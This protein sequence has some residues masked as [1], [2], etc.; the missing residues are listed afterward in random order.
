MLDTLNMP[1]RFNLC[2]D[3]VG[4]ADHGRRSEAIARLRSVIEQERQIPHSAEDQGY[5]R[6]AEMVLD[7]LEE[8]LP[9]HYAASSA[10]RA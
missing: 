5:L 9:S 8:W 10:T 1:Q 4:E 3:I 7:F 2:S 6:I